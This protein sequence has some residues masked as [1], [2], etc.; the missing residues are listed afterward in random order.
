MRVWS[1]MILVLPVEPE[2]AAIALHT[3]HANAP[4]AEHWVWK[5]PYGISP[6]MVMFN[7]GNIR[8]TW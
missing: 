8:V 5:R 2:D 1:Q 4:L 6:G 7:L 3:A